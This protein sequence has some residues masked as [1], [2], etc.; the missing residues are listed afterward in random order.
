[1]HIDKSV[2]HNI[3]YNMFKVFL[4]L[5]SNLGDREL[6]LRTAINS[7]QQHV[8]RVSKQSSVYQTQAW[9]RTTEPDY[10]NQVIL[11][12]TNLSPRDVLSK[13]LNIEMELGR[14]REEKWGSRTMDIDILFYADDIIDEPG[15]IIPHPELH[16][17]RFTLEPLNEIA[18]EMMHPLLNRT[19]SKLKNDL[20]DC[21]VVKKL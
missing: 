17:R 7:L 12:E 9:G 20:E 18:P 21:L 5:G 10:L 3:C 16:K 19:I 14:R 13:I 8:G 1:L 4:L 6:Y 2:N 11:L 15:L